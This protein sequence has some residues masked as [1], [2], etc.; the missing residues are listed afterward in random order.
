[1]K[2]LLGNGEGLRMLS[3][4]RLMRLL[5]LARLLRLFRMFK[6]LSTILAGFQESA[7]ALGWSGAFLMII[8]YVFAIMGTEHF[9]KAAQPHCEAGESRMLRARGAAAEANDHSTCDIYQWEDDIGNQK[10]LFGTVP[11]SMLTLFVCLTE[12]C[13]LDVVRPMIV[14]TPMVMLYWYLFMFTTTFGILNVIVGQ[15]CEKML[16]AANEAE[17]IYKANEEESKQKRIDKLMKLFSVMDEDGSQRI[18]REEWTE[19]ILNNKEVT[20]CIEDLGLAYEPDIFGVLDLDGSGSVTTTEFYEG[21]QLLTKAGNEPAK[22]KD[23][24]KTYLVCNAVKEA[25]QH[26]SEILAAGHQPDVAASNAASLE[27]MEGRICSAI[28][29]LKEEVAAMGTKFR[30]VDAR[31]CSLEASLLQKDVKQQ[32]PSQKFMSGILGSCRPAMSEAA[33]AFKDR[34]QEDEL[35]HLH[36]PDKCVD[37]LNGCNSSSEL[38][39]QVTQEDIHE[40]LHITGGTRQV[41]HEANEPSTELSRAIQRLQSSHTQSSVMV[42][43]MGQKSNVE[44]QL[45][46]SANDGDPKD[47]RQKHTPINLEKDNPETTDVSTIPFH[48]EEISTIPAAL[49]TNN[50]TGQIGVTIQT[51]L[52]RMSNLEQQLQK[53]HL[54]STQLHAKIARE[55]VATMNLMIEA[56]RT[57]PSIQASKVIDELS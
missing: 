15:I 9:G 28:N 37:C 35:P 18:S 46:N 38:A 22:S 31:V 55:Q 17:M 2:P 20:H 16:E 8:V 56:L 23:M 34:L 3:V 51:I 45:M 48:V 13:A 52:Y 33:H 27:A 41:M 49:G 43:C 47:H 10:T 29:S 11:I 5:R 53:N 14:E 57:E 39:V 42:H 32:E 25:Q 50:V 36:Q 30:S 1:M 6:E 44:K 54:D 40:V 12:G 24:I 26:F 7:K 19:A 4:L 21:I